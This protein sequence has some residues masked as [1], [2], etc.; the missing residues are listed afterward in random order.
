[1]TEISASISSSEFSSNVV[2]ISCQMKSRKI[3]VAISNDDKV[4]AFLCA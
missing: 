3:F 4:F 2:E 1:M